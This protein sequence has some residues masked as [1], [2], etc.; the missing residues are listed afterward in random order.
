MPPLLPVPPPQFHTDSERYAP[1]E[2]V[3]SV[4]PPTCTIFV[5]SDGNSIEPVNASSSPLALKKVCPCA[6]ICLKIASHVGSGPPPPHEQ[7]NCFAKLSFAIRLS[8]SG[9]G[10]G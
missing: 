9:H 6:A 1:L 3:V 2:V 5:L 4:V 10:A 8:R 7:L